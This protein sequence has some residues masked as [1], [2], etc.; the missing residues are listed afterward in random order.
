VKFVAILAGIVLLLVAI[1]H[2]YLA[3]VG[4]T[5]TV[6]HIP[7]MADVVVPMT[8]RWICAGVAAL[9]GILLLVLRK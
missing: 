9:L 5:I 6:A 4:A 2:A 1:A 3:Y 7:H 8:A